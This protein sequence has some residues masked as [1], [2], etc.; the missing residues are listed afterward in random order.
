[1]P[2]HGVKANG[3]ALRPRVQQTKLAEYKLDARH[4]WDSLTAVEGKLLLCY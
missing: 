1:L 2:A 3:K 4:V